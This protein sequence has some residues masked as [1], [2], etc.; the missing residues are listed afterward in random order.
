M[1]TGF[2]SP[3]QGYED[4][5]LDLNRILIRHPAATVLMEIQTSRYSRAGIYEGDIVI[6]DRSLTPGKKSIVV[7]EENGEFHIGRLEKISSELIV[8]G[9]VS[10]IIHQTLLGG[11]DDFTCGR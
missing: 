3:A 8:F 2:P 5:S 4:N 11:A 10:H 6:I 9:V 7:F 1:I